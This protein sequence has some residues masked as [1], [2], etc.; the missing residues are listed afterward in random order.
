[1][2]LDGRVSLTNLLNHLAQ[3]APQ[4]L[5]KGEPEFSFT[6]LSSRLGKEL[7][8]EFLSSLDEIRLEL[9]PRHAEDDS[10]LI[11]FWDE[12]ACEVTA[13]PHM[14]LEKPQ[15]LAY[16][17][18]QFGDNWK[19]PL[20][21]FEVIYAIDYLDVGHEPTT[22][23]GVE[24]FAPTDETLAAKS[25]PKSEITQWMKRGKTLTLST[26]RVEAASNTIAFEAG[27]NRVAN[28]IT[29]MRASAL[30]G[31]LKRTMTDEL[32]QWK[33]SGSYLV[34][35]VTEGEPPNWPRVSVD[36]LVQSLWTWATISDKALE[37]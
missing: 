34:R 24:F 20:S 23:D 2:K 26:V 22:L 19:K 10:L 32:L 35:P 18:D 21:E 1:M 29:L 5:K 33:L 9:V 37:G 17:V 6:R 13:N 16:L 12:L 11:A 25:I 36:R 8:V 30:C 7:A 27:R 14:Y 15:A 31:L 3:S 4:R 28:A